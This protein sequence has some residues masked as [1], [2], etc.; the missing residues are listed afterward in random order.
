MLI[1]VVAL[2]V[3]NVNSQVSSYGF[4]P[5]LGTFVPL[6]GGT[7]TSLTATADTGLSTAF[8]I[9]FNFVYD[10]V[11]YTTVRANSNGLLCFNATGSS[12]AAN[13]LATTTTAAR[14]A[15]APLWDDLQCTQGATYQLNGVAPNRT[16][17]VEWLNMEWN[18]LST[19]PVISFQVKIGRAHV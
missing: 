1:T 2:T 9:G 12:T 14:P 7:A 5:F 17:T 18:W 19:T 11:T 16:L 8:P 6:S 3:G 10:G 13:N 4:N 15:L